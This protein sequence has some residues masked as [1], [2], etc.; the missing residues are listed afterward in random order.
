MRFTIET[1]KKLET[2]LEIIRENTK[3][4]T[5]R[6]GFFVPDEYFSG[7]V[8]ETGFKIYRNIHYRNKF[9]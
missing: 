4:R 2:V 7:Q 5:S 6:F 1:N 3:E 8:T 9:L